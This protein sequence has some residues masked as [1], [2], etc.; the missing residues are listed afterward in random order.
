MTRPTQ[1]TYTHLPCSLPLA[2]IQSAHPSAPH[3]LHRSLPPIHPKPHHPPP[4]IPIMLLTPVRPAPPPTSLPALIILPR[5]QVPAPSH[6]PRALGPC[7]PRQEAARGGARSAECSQRVEED[8]GSAES[9]DG[10]MLAGGAGRGEEGWDADAD[11]A[12]AGPAPV[13]GETGR[14]GSLKEAVG[15]K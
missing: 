6:L 4:L 8:E 3:H 14:P 7:E 10:R 5:D 12:T 1:G 11:A 2:S 9:W 13:E 15:R